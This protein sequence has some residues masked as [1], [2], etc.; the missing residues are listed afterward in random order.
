MVINTTGISSQG[1]T[2]P[3]IVITAVNPRPIIIISNIQIGILVSRAPVSLENLEKDK[4]IDV[5]KEY[6]I[7][8]PVQDTTKRIVIEKIH[9][10]AYNATKH[11]S[12]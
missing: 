5:E 11:A 8:S 12:M 9:A 1:F 6:L 2:L 3:T 4:C 7:N 10:C